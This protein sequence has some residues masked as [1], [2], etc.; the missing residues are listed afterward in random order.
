MM[1][2]PPGLVQ[3]INTEL[4]PGTVP[5]LHSIVRVLPTIAPCTE[6][7]SSVTVGGGAIY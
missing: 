3:L 5:T 7:G 2:T 6:F 1:V 4:T